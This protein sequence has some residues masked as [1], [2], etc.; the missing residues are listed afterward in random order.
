MPVRYLAL[1]MQSKP[2]K[3]TP[4]LAEPA[5]CVTLPRAARDSVDVQS[6]IF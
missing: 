3:I 4:A 5:L 2:D 1:E 6:R